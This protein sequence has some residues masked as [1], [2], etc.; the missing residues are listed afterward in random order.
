MDTLILYIDNKELKQF[1]ETKAKEHNLKLSTNPHPDSGF[2]LYCINDI[3]CSGDYDIPF[4]TFKVDFY[5]K[6]VMYKE[7][8][9]K[10][11]AYY[12]YARSSIS[13]TPFR[14]ANNVG[15]I[16]SGYRGNLIAKLDCY[17]P[18]A[19]IEKDKSF[20]QICQPNLEPFKVIIK[21]GDEIDTTERGENGFGSTGV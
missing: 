19:I 18:N 17:K 10:S 6:G 5:V 12:L 2:N 1:Y 13:N 7:C 3:L 14:L 4:K 9:L 8:K 11:V 20:V 16:D 15:I 21:N